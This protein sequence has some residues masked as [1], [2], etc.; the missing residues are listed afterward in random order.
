MWAFA[1]AVVASQLYEVET[2]PRLPHSGQPNPL[3]AGY[4]TR[5]H[6]LIYL[7]GIQTDAHF[8]N[9]CES[10]GRPDLLE[11]PRFA[12]GVARLANAPAC[13]QLLDEIFAA[14]DLADW[15][16]VLGDLDTP[17]TV[18]QTA[19]EAAGD[20][21]VLANQIVTSLEA[22]CGPVPMVS[23]PAQFDGNPLSLTRAPAHGE[24]TEEIL[25]ELGHSWN[26]IAV[27]KAEDAVG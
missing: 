1:P 3:V 26:D 22:P 2:I 16:A 13:I 7:A 9:F 4:Q 25:L 27:L 19:A 17:W 8:D 11:D 12:T 20:P 15:V 18:V 24:H 21:Q 23:S 14:R 5:D 6:R 10:I